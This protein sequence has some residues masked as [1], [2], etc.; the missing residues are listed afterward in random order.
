MVFVEPF[1]GFQFIFPF[2]DQIDLNNSN[3]SVFS[4]FTRVLRLNIREPCLLSNVEINTLPTI[5][6]TRKANVWIVKQWFFKLIETSWNHNIHYRL[7]VV[8][9]AT[10]RG[11][12]FLDHLP[13]IGMFST[14]NK[15]FVIVDLPAFDIRYA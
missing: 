12:T 8:F 6:T 11:S 4:D 3:V 13:Y 10:G 1:R 2:P 7:N 5:N 15:A 14:P 9:A